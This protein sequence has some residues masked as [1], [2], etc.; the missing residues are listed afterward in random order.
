MLMTKAT[1]LVGLCL[2]LAT[3][4]MASAQNLIVNPDFV[5]DLSGWNIP[6]L[7]LGYGVDWIGGGGAD[8]PGS[9]RINVNADVGGSQVVLTQ[10][11]AVAASTS[12]DFGAH[13]FLV[14][15]LDNIPVGQLSVAWYTSG[16]CVNV[17]GGTL[18]SAT[19]NT[20]NAWQSVSAAGQM[21]PA[22]TASAKVSLI[23]QTPGSGTATLFYDDV[24]LTASG[25]P[26]T[27]TPTPAPAPVPA[28]GRGGLLVLLACMAVAGILILRAR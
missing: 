14:G 4:G 16:G 12:Y 17:A 27:P 7:P 28:T 9:V 8:G 11:V 24:Y 19:N 22:G 10:C 23:F 1:N 5:S 26:A 15:G 20:V 18:S 25:A 2:L 6:L 3:A 13:V 21:S